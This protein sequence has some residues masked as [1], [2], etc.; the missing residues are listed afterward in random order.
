[1]PNLISFRRILSLGKKII[2][3]V[4]NLVEQECSGFNHKGHAKNHTCEEQKCSG[5]NFQIKHIANQ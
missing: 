5:F 3:H 4:K 2:R 1:M